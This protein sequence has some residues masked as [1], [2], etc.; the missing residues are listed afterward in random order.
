MKTKRSTD[1]TDS[2]KADDKKVKLETMASKL[3]FKN[4][5]NSAYNLAKSLLGK[6]LVR[7]YNDEIILKAKI[8]ETECYPGGEDKASA[9]YNNR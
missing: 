3:Q 8:V 2:F 7:K 5:N 9:T 6:I 1:E 4:F